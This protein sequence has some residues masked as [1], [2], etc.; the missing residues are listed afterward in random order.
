MSAVPPVPQ[1]DQPEPPR[2]CG[3]CDFFRPVR[4]AR[5]LCFYNPPV[6]HVVMVSV[7]PTGKLATAGVPQVEMRQVPASMR[8]ETDASDKCAQ[9]LF[10]DEPAPSEFAAVAVSD[11]LRALNNHAN[12]IAMFLREMV[13]TGGKKH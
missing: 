6:V 11:E 8:P 9:H 10:S 2:K 7:P 4:E 3:N 1:E 13:Q 12:R 5:G